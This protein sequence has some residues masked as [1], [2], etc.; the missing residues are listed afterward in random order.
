MKQVRGRLLGLVCGVLGGLVVTSSPPP[1]L[2]Q[3]AQGGEHS[4]VVSGPLPNPEQVRLTDQ[5]LLGTTNADAN[6]AIHGANYSNQRFSSLRQINDSNVASLVPVA[7]VQTGMTA[8]FETTP[9]VINGV[10]YLTTPMVN[11]HMKIMALNAAT[12]QPLWTHDHRIGPAKF[13]C[14]PVNRGV[15]AAYGKLY[16]GTLDA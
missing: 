15:A 8:S 9:L 4:V 2:A 16:F 14:G 7:I 3:G 1:V 5:A 13:C 10:M 11:G 12:G 6:W